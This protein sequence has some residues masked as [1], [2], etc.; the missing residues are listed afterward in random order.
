[1]KKMKKNI[2]ILIIF[3]NAVRQHNFQLLNG[4]IPA[5]KLVKPPNVD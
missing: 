5:G 1:M 2:N 4:N 3:F